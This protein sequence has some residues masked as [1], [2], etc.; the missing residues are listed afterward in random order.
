MTLVELEG[1]QS[2]TN[3]A[4]KNQDSRDAVTLRRGISKRSHKK[5]GDCEQSTASR[6]IHVPV[7]PAIM[8]FNHLIRVLI[9]CVEYRIL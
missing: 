5:I 9:H 4:G 2:L 7:T 1:I 3:Y 6:N 8:R